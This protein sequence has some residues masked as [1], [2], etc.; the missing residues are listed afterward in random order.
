MSRGAT[1]GSEVKLNVQVTFVTAETAMLLP[2]PLFS[3]RPDTS[4]ATMT[5]L[6][7]NVNIA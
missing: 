7:F 6:K 3:T 2:M 1:N 5:R 4:G